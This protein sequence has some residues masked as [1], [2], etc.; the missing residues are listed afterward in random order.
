MS[1]AKELAAK[2]LQRRASKAAAVDRQRYEDRKL[3]KKAVEVWS[4]LLLAVEH[5]VK[6][7]NSPFDTAQ[8]F[9]RTTESYEFE[10]IK[11]ERLQTVAKV[12]LNSSIG[13]I[14]F[15]LFRRSGPRASKPL[16][17][18]TFLIQLDSLIDMG[19]QEPV[20]LEQITDTITSAVFG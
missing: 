7:Y 10:L 13:A 9:L 6:E 17:T 14:E 19:S 2:E 5:W 3:H 4:A 16:R 11:E 15:E 18:G 1:R 12:H 20:I 8:A